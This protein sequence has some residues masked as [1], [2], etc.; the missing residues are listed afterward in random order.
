MNSFDSSMAEPADCGV[1]GVDGPLMPELD[2][3]E[4]GDENTVPGLTLAPRRCAVALSS[5]PLDPCTTRF[6]PL[7]DPDDPCGEARLGGSG[8]GP[9]RD[10]ADRVGRS[11]R[12]RVPP[13]PRGAT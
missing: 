8:P 9:S 11:R 13:W 3:V 2:G 4:A 12:R 10:I 5:D 1:G 7:A 6:E